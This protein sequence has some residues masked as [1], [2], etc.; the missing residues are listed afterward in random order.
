MSRTAREVIAAYQF[1]WPNPSEWDELSTIQLD[2]QADQ[3]ISALDAAGFVIVPKEP[4]EEMI[5]AGAEED[6]W[7][8]SEG[9][10]PQPEIYRAMIAA[11]FSSKEGK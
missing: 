11:Y 1:E 5:A 10:A 8:Y 4:T 6:A 3:I 7:C 2:D 9:Q